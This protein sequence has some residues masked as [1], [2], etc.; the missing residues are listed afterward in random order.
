VKD[1]KERTRFV[2]AC[3]GGRRRCVV[4]VEGGCFFEWLAISSKLPGCVASPLVPSGAR[5]G[6]EEAVI[7]K[8]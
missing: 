4:L 6:V 1:P 3:K 2:N 8:E 7:F 5:A